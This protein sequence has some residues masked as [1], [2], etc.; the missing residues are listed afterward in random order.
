MGRQRP[1]AAAFGGAAHACQR[2]FGTTER[3]GFRPL[4][5]DGEAQHDGDRWHLRMTV[6]GERA[7]DN[8]HEQL[9]KLYDCLDVQ[10]QPCSRTKHQA[11]KPVAKR[12]PHPNP[13]LRLRRKGGSR[14]CGSTAN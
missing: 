13:P 1:G 10:V 11:H 7:A 4:S 9:A 6:E 5:V 14:N 2:A 8:L 12:A 3:R